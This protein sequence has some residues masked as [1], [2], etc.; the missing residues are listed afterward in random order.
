MIV[1]S[2]S[3]F[4]EFFKSLIKSSPV[5]LIPKWAKN[6]VQ[7]ISIR[8]LMQALVGVLETDQAIG[9]SFDICGDEVLTYEEM[10]KVFS[11]LLNKKKLIIYTWISYPRLYSYLASLVTPLPESIIRAMII[12][13]RF[14]MVCGNSENI[15]KKLYKPLRFRE[16]VIKALS[17][18]EQDAVYTRWSDEYPR[19]HELAIKLNALEK[20]PRF[21][22]SYFRL[23]DSTAEDLFESFCQIGG[24]KG[25]LNN[26]WMWKLRGLMD[27]LLLGVGISRGRRSASDLRINDVIDFWRVE[28]ILKNRKLL[29]RAEMKSPGMAWLEFEVEMKHA[30]M[31]KLIVTAYYAPR[32]IFG[33]LYWY[34][35][36]P[37]HHIIFTNLLKQIEKMS[38]ENSEVTGS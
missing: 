16:S 12:R 6:K 1:G 9:K 14:E 32:G 29:L 36:L 17:K 34:I 33:Y 18:E 20:S 26:N 38:F 3:A 25:W 35:F 4:F 13:G 31:R 27:R 7:P 21:I 23:T 22:S 19:A 10:L 24:Q 11:K 30:T 15:M 37:F 8:S 28:E 2:G 5:L